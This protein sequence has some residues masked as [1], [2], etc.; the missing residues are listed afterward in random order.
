MV[1][2]TN[3]VD[4]GT[5]DAPSV[6]DGHSLAVLAHALEPTRKLDDTP[7]EVY[8][9]RVKSLKTVGK[10]F[11]ECLTKGTRAERVQK[12]EDIYLYMYEQEGEKGFS[13]RKESLRK[14]PLYLLLHAD[15]YDPPKTQPN[16]AEVNQATDVVLGKFEMND[17]KTRKKKL[18]DHPV[19]RVVITLKWR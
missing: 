19:M 6:H 7:K 15:R 1:E 3:N 4:T 16:G 2:A 5:S 8:D 14:T 13:E 9:N 18:L 11:D 17:I 10:Q 12:V